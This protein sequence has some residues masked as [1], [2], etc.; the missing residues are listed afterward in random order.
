MEILQEYGIENVE[1]IV[2]WYDGKIVY[3]E[4]SIHGN[5]ME[6]DENTEIIEQ[7]GDA[8]LETKEQEDMIQN[9]NTGK[10]YTD[11]QQAIDEANEKETL[12]VMK[13]YQQISLVTIL[14]QK[15]IIL[16]LNGNTITTFR[17]IYNKGNLTII[18]SKENGYLQSHT[19]E[20]LIENE[21]NLGLIRRNSK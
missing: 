1:G 3:S 8:Y 16:D 18:D 12:Q 19:V 20:K 13:S 4:Q 10:R 9:V 6:I 7:H 5:I 17:N 21:G 2:N 11:L 14:E 15:E